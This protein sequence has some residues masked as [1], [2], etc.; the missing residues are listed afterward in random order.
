MPDIAPLTILTA[1]PAATHPSVA[2]LAADRIV[3]DLALAGALRATDFRALEVRAAAREI[4]GRELGA[5]CSSPEQLAAVLLAYG[6]VDAIGELLLT[7]LSD[8]P[9][10]LAAAMEEV[11]ADWAE[12]PSAVPGARGMARF[13]DGERA[14]RV[15]GWNLSAASSW[16]IPDGQVAAMSLPWGRVV[17]EASMSA[18]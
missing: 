10:A 9:Y 11:A 14:C 3:A 16:V 6:V 17:L 15:A 7:Q 2:A 13:D 8:V 4:V 12:N 5:G 1:R 18:P